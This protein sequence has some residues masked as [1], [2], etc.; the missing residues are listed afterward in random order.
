MIWSHVAGCLQLACVDGS[1]VNSYDVSQKALVFAS[2]VFECVIA[3]SS[4]SSSSGSKL[5]KNIDGRKSKGGHGSATTASK[6]SKGAS[7]SG[8]SSK[9]GK[10]ML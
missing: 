8:S 7:K 1:D 10:F 2:Q 6:V 3:P 5:S 9:T 4:A